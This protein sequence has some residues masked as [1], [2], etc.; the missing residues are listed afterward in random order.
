[1][2]NMKRKI[3]GLILLILAFTL[4]FAACKK[5]PVTED[6]TDAD[7]KI[8]S[9]SVVAGSVPTEVEVGQTPDFSGIKVK[10]SYDDNTSK[11]IGYADVKLSALDTATAGAK[12]VTVTYGDYKTTFS[13]NVIE[14]EAVL[15]SIKIVA[16]SVAASVYQGKIYDTTELQVAGIYSD[17]TERGLPI[18]D[19]TIS[20]IDTSTA[21][22][23]T[24]TVKYGDFTATMTVKVIGITGMKVYTGTVATK[25]MVGETLDTSNLE[26]EVTYA[27]NTTE[28]V[29]A[30]DLVIGTVDTASYGKKELSI[31]YKGF[32]IKHSIEVVGL[33]EISVLNTDGFKREVLVGS[34]FSA[35]GIQ[36]EATYSDGTNKTFGADKLTVGTVDTATAGEKNLTVSYTEGGITKSADV[37]ITVVGV[38]SMTVNTGTLKNEIL[39]GES[40]SVSGIQVSG[41]YT[42][43]KNFSLD[44]D[45]LSIDGAIDGNTAGE[46]TIRI[47]Y[48]DKTIDHTVKVCEITAIRATLPNKVV[49]AGQ[50]IS[51][52]GLE[53]YG[54]YN[55]SKPT[56]VKLTDGISTNIDSI[57][58]NTEADKDLVVTWG[59]FNYTIKITT[60]APSLSGLEIRGADDTVRVDESYDTSSLNVWALYGNETDEKITAYDVSIAA[61]PDNAN[62]KIVTVTYTE[63]G[64]T[65]TATKTVTVVGI[66]SIAVVDGTLS[67]LINK[68]QEFVCTGVKVIV[69]YADGSNK[70]VESGITVDVPELVNGADNNITVTYEGVSCTH[71]CHVKAVSSIEI[72]AGLADVK[73][74]GYATDVSKLELKITYSDSTETVVLASTLGEAVD[75]DGDEKGALEFTVTY[76][77][78][79]ATKTFVKAT[80]YQIHA[81]NGTVPGY[82]LQ[83][84]MPSFD[85][86]RVTVI[87]QYEYNGEVKEEIYLIGLDDPNLT[88]NYTDEVYGDRFD[89]VTP[90]DRVVQFTYDTQEPDP[91]NEGQT[92]KLTAAAKIIVKGVDYIEIVP[93]S[94]LTTVKK[95]QTVDTDKIQVKVNY[96]DGTYLYVSSSELKSKSTVDT[97]TVGTKTLTVTYAGYNTDFT[98][99][100]EVTVVDTANANTGMI[101]AAVLPDEVIVRETYKKNFKIQ[102]SPYYYVGDDNPFV[103]YLNVAVL[104]SNGLLEED[105]NGRKVATAVRVFEN[106]AE[107]TGDDLTSVVKFDSENNTYD[108]TEAAIKRT[109]TLKIRPADNSRYLDESAVTKSLTV[110]VVDGYNVYEEYELNLIT[111]VAQDSWWFDGTGMTDAQKFSQGTEV[112][113]F[114]TAKGIE[115]YRNGLKGIVLHRNMTLEME[116]LPEKYFVTYTK[117]GKT[118]TSMID[119]M[120]IFN[121]QASVGDSFS[122]YGNCYSIFTYNLP[123]VAHKNFGNNSDNY[124]SSTLFELQANSSEFS[125]YKESRAFPYA[126]IRYNICDLALRDNDPHSNDQSASERHMRG[127]SAFQVGESTVNIT[128]V[129]VDAFMMSLSSEE[130]GLVLNLNK[131][132]FYNAWQGHL[133]LWSND[134]FY[135]N[136]E[137]VATAADNLPGQKVYI[138]DSLLGKCGGPVIL[139]QNANRGEDWNYNQSI[140]VFV[141]AETDKNLYS[142]VTGEEAWFVAVNQV[143]LAKKI[144]TA[145]LLIQGTA[146]AYKS[147]PELAPY[148]ASTSFINNTKISGVD[149]VNMKMVVMGDGDLVGG[150]MTQHRG[151][152][153]VAGSTVMNMKMNEG[154]NDALRTIVNAYGADKNIFQSSGGGIAYHAMEPKDHLAPTI[155]ETGNQGP[156][157]ALFQGDYLNIYTSGIGILLEYYP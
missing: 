94:V 155:P 121:H 15:E 45:D 7:V 8:T 149:T 92:R 88:V 5:D 100:V 117:D 41:K 50:A 131:V 83:G 54:I 37:K 23:K 60:T 14:K 79:T 105:V 24:L 75:Y 12:T 93:G 73:R 104:N 123:A 154:E 119:Q 137:L 39:K 47:T 151:S 99:S 29:K 111:N 116:D 84:N 42:N 120:G 148:V 10:V 81:L 156:N 43:G 6:E 71:V 103:L 38:E 118:Y 135:E 138:T 143:P 1:M 82:L 4:C 89:C 133:F 102:D 128:N 34:S 114:L 52:N 70:R 31:S 77:G 21:G 16:G 17:G 139:A 125:T 112:Y 9:I 27:D 46:Q 67:T 108:F 97:S 98:A 124:S 40:F 62:Q 134:H 136:Q 86:F 19:V 3:I 142:Y 53:V 48:L 20:G 127:L 68:G 56:E 78:K 95:G 107:L 44:G 36:V 22:D 129:N 144:L 57:D 150:D 51:L 122:I 147:V 115:S 153:T 66:E 2:K 11:E 72:F 109:F 65:K 49:A 91:E 101:F 87:Y 35:A 32:E 18:A 61:D 132:K 90:G 59:G 152:Y 13:I 33:T 28:P 96:T 146:N 126:D 26:V 106:G 157:P 63:N 145:N 58:I 130:D 113:N 30:I 141:D 76:E 55:T 74:E 64:V 110:T 85:K 140:D 80:I 25:L 69:T